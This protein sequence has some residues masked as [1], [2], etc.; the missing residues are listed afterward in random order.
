MKKNFYEILEID[1]NASPEIVE[2]AY[3]TLVKKYHPDL[4]NG[5]KKTK[6]E[7]KLK[8]INKAYETLSDPE[9]RKAYD[10]TLPEQVSAE[11][12]ENLRRQKEYMKDRITRME[13]QN[14]GYS[15]DQQ[16]PNMNYTPQQNANRQAYVNQATRAYQQ[17]VNDAINKAYR[18]AYV[19]DL[20]NRGYNIRY[21]KTWKDYLTIFITVIMIF[22]IL[23]IA[24]HIPFIH[25]YLVDLYNSNSV[26]H[27]IVDIFINFFNN[28]K[29]N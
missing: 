19:Q 23:F 3:K 9:K 4:Q 18:D 6:Y 24:W 14:N 17:Q 20:R 7:E 13:Q 1:L 5:D 28:F 29:N 12:Y 25:D 27:T 8:V 10:A 16:Q 2:K 26:I 11:E 21:K 22:V 15:R